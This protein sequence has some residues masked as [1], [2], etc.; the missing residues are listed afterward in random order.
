MTSWVTAASGRGVLATRTLTRTGARHICTSWSAHNIITSKYPDLEVVPGNLVT[1]VFKN[2]SKWANRVATECA[3]TGRQSTYSQLMDNIARMGGML[4]KLG[5]KKGDVVAIVMLNRPEYPIVLLG[6]ASI[7]AVANLL[8]TS[9]TPGK[10]LCN[11]AVEEICRHLNVS[12][13]KLVVG[14]TGLEKNLDAALALHKKPVVLMMN[15]PSSI[16]GSI[17]LQHVLENTA[18]SFADPVE[19]SRSDIAVMPY[20]SGT[21]GHPKGVTISHDSY[22]EAV[23]GYLPFFHV[24]GFFVKIMAAFHTGSKL[25]C[26]PK[27]NPDTFTRD[28]NHYKV[29]YLHTVP[30]VLNFLAHSPTVTPEALTSLEVTLCGAA[31]VA[32]SAAQALMEKIGRPII[33]QEGYGMTEVLLTHLTPK[34]HQ[35]IGNCGRLLPNVSAKV[36]DTVTGEELPPNHNGEICIKTPCMMS[37]YFQ[38][39]DATSAIFDKE[40]W[41]YS[42]DIGRYDEEGFFTIVDRTKELIKVK[43]LQVAPSEL[44]DVILQHPKVVE[45][46]V[47]GVP[48]ERL[49]EAPRAYVVTSAPTTETDIKE[50]VKLKL[51]P[52]KHLAGGVVFINEIPKSATGKLLRKEL[53]KTALL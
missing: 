47:V 18:V 23:F 7:G 48:D 6:A 36:V 39:T 20:S 50:F 15:G 1:H 44:E 43:A 27:F 22:Q 14:D 3:V 32:L 28:I 11:T 21:T 40:G 24:Y 33:F 38:N 12:N 19:T 51:A 37:G 52:H 30:T 42:G 46:G 41:L 17:N 31:P 25:V 4:T 35:Q 49:G 9:S 5:V 16:S 26:V 13:P 10:S 34:T 8:S 53:K 45:V 2:S 29:R